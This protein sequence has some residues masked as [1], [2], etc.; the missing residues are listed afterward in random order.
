MPRSHLPGAIPKRLNSQKTLGNLGK[1][2][3][4]IKGIFAIFSHFTGIIRTGGKRASRDHTKI[5]SLSLFGAKSALLPGFWVGGCKLRDAEIAKE[6]TSNGGLDH[7]AGAG[8]F[9]SIYVPTSP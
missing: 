5:K 1:N 2:Q 7:I 6:R 4:I 8:S 3:K 9:L